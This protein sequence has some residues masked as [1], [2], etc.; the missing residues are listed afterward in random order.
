MKLKKGQLIIVTMNTYDP[1]KIDWV[2]TPNSNI[3]T[4]ILIKKFME[5]PASERGAHSKYMQKLNPDKVISF[6][7]DEFMKW[8]VKEKIITKKKFVEIVECEDLTNEFKQTF[9]LAKDV[10]GD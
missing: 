9:R 1:E 3:D 8:L 7:L 5:K 10:Y 4:D 2:I 6:S